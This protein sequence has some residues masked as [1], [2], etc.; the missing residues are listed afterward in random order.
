METKNPSREHSALLT[1]A[2]YQLGEKGVSK[3]DRV[4]NAN[5]M[6][7][8]TGYVVRLQ[9]ISIKMTPIMFL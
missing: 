3:N 5:K 8:Q 1:Q 2:A 6:V 7:E 9:R 4:N